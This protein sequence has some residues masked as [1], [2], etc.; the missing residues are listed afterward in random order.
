MYFQ[1]QIKIKVDADPLIV[2]NIIVISKFFHPRD[3]LR[4]FA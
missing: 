4:R 3:A 1:W 2:T